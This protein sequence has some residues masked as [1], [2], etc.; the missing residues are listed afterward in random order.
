MP[1]GSVEI[2]KTWKG[3]I[4]EFLSSTPLIVEQQYG[5]ATLSSLF[6]CRGAF[7]RG[8]RVRRDKASIFCRIQTKPAERVWFLRCKG[9]FVSLD[10]PKKFAWVHFGS[11]NLKFTHPWQKSAQGWQKLHSEQL[12]RAACPTAAVLRVPLLYG[13]VES[14]LDSAP[15]LEYA[16]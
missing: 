12:V 9:R 1:Q 5:M 15:L 14:P 6:I 10:H 16:D 13:P 4:S 3:C 7:E 11:G 2:G 8:L